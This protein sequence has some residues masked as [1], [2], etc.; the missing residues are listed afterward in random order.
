MI[1][2]PPRPGAG[3]AVSGSVAD[4]DES[5]QPREISLPGGRST[6]GIVRIERTVR[7]PLHSDAFIRHECLRH[8]EG[9]GFAGAP[10]FLGVDDKGREI[11]SFLPGHVPADLGHFDDPQLTA[12]AGLLRR[13]HD[14]TA[15]MAI[16]RSAGAEVM[17]HNDWAPTNAVFVDDVPVALIDFDTARPGERLWDLGYSA[18]TWLDLGNDCYSGLEQCRRLAVFADGYGIASCSAPRIAAYALARQSTLAASTRARGKHDIAD[19]AAACADWTA[20]HVVE[21]LLPTGYSRP[22]TQAATSPHHFPNAAPPA[23]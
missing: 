8:L 17:C 7:R 18:F 22:E 3:A 20:R 19:W 5:A 15:E 23:A 6:S 13:F 11:L 1:G 14:A 21:R 2:T 10:R 9:Q 16:V 4:R 12:A